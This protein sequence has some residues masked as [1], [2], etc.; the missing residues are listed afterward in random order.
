MNYGI[1]HVIPL[2]VLYNYYAHIKYR[3][4]SIKLSPPGEAG[5]YLF[6]AC[7]K[8]GLKEREG[9]KFSSSERRRGGGGLERADYLRGGLNRGF[10]VSFLTRP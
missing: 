6:Q 9:Y 7:L 5:A 4:S 3:K 10:R 1:F 8:V 2:E